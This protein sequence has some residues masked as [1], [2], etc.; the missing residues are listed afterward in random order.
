MGHIAL[1]SILNFNRWCNSN[2]TIRWFTSP[3]LDR[4]QYFG[5]T[6]GYMENHLREFKISYVASRD[7]LEGLEQLPMFP[8]IFGTW[9]YWEM[10]PIGIGDGPIYQLHQLMY[11]EQ[12]DP[13]AKCNSC[14][15]VIVGW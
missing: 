13:V 12:E 1:M 7:V 8:S 15:K 6:L 5:N 10:P 9:G 11:L 14:I 4:A 3:S 2:L